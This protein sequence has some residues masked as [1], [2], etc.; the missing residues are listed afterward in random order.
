MAKYLKKILEVISSVLF[1]LGSVSGC[2]GTPEIAHVNDTVEPGTSVKRGGATVELYKGA[3]HAQIKQGSKLPKIALADAKMND[4]TLGA[5]GVV[6]I[7]NVVPSLDTKVCEEQTHELGE[8]TNINPNIERIV[9]SRDLP[10]AQKRFAE[11]AG[12]TNIKYLSDYKSGQFGKATGLLMKKSELLTRAIIV[13][14]GNGVVKHYQV[15]PEITKLP[16]MTRAIDIANHLV[17][18]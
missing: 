6:R 7:I 15:V 4:Y 5:N 8:A 3:P 16:N 14:D 10:A 11:E 1:V 12:L 2:A 13:V 9:I 18:K 17:T